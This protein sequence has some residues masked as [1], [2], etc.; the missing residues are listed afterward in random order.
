[1]DICIAYWIIR[2]TVV[3]KHYSESINRIFCIFVLYILFTKYGFE[4]VSLYH[5]RKERIL[6]MN[7]DMTKYC[8]QHYEN[9][10]NIGWKT[11]LDKESDKELERDI[12][13]AP[14]FIEKLMQYCNQPINRELNGKYNIIEIKG[15]KYVKGFGE[16]RIIDFEKGIR[17]AS[18]NVI[19]DDIINGKYIPPKE[20]VDAV[21][22][23]PAFDSVEY[24]KFFEEYSEENLWGENEEQRK[25]IN[26]ATEL[27]IE[28]SVRFRNYI[29]EHKLINIVTLKGSLLNYAIE[30]G[31]E[32]E[33]FWLIENGININAF[34]G[35]ELLTAIRK[36]ST[37]IGKMLIDRNIVVSS[38][39]MKDNPLVNAI[40]YSN[41]FLVETLMKK[42][43]NLI[44][45][46]SN[47]YVKDCT[48]L[49]VALRVNNK[50]IIDIVRRYLT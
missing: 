7:S 33:A 50:E 26:K 1:M 2:L 21:L 16:I 15:E 30:I 40:R 20:F 43:R 18:P 8:F 6:K 22:S 35:L 19:I 5:L 46:Y 38:D 32:Q 25:K 29:L 42:Y 49:S 24:Q 23:S 36:N 4:N 13:D 28:N 34:D 48:M 41:S 9:A 11:K 39:E 45:T 10:Y 27:M 14:F 47:E 44:V 17:Y 3:F 31:N 12:I 37:S